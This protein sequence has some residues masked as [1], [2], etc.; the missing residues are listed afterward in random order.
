M[1]TRDRSVVRVE[2]P[3][4]FPEHLAAVDVRPELAEERRVARQQRGN[5][6]V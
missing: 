4:V 5:C 1:L 6:E 2:Q 3:V